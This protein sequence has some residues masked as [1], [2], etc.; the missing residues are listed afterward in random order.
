MLT[1]SIPSPNRSTVRN[2]PVAT[3]S[4]PSP[5]R[6]QTCCANDTLSNG[7]TAGDALFKSFATGVHGIGGQ[8]V[9]TGIVLVGKTG[10]LIRCEFAESDGL[11][12]TKAQ[13]PLDHIHT[14][15]TVIV[16]NK[17]WR[18]HTPRFNSLVLLYFCID[19]DRQDWQL[20]FHPRPRSQS[21]FVSHVPSIV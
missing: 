17:P 19:V 9:H 13:Q 16:V 8:Q 11:K 6:K 15:T 4:N 2:E 18:S 7:S 5:E 21:A 1:G 20:L 10:L 12:L 3:F 14:E